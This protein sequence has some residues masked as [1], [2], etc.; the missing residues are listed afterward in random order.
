MLTFRQKI[1]HKNVMVVG[2]I[3]LDSFVQGVVERISPE[4]P[5][6]VLS[7]TSETRMLGGA[8]NALRNL[9][10]LGAKSSIISLTGNDAAR[11]TL[12]RHV[13][14]TGVSSSSL[15]ADPSRPTTQKTRFVSGQHQLLRA[16]L[17]KTHNP[18]ED[19]E[20]ALIDAIEAAM[21]DADALVLSDYGKGVLSERVI[22]ASIEAARAKGAPVLVDPKGANF[23][24]Y[25]GAGVITPNRKELSAALGGMPAHTDEEIEIAA[26]RLIEKTGIDTVIVTRSEDGLS[27]IKKETAPVHIRGA[28]LEVFDVSGAGD[29][30]IATLAAGLACGLDIETAARLANEAGGIVVGK[31][32]TAQITIDDLISAIMPETA[33]KHMAS[34][35]QARERIER[36]RAQ[37]LKIGFT[38][39]CF[40]ILHA[41]HARYLNTARKKC[42]R[43][44]LGLNADSSVRRLKGETRPVNNENDR[45]EVLAA[46]GCVDMVVVFGD[47]PGEQDMPCELIAF[48]KPDIH[49]KGGD[50]KPKD[51]PEAKIVWAYGGEVE[52]L[53]LVAGLS[54]TNTLKKMAS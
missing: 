8:G 42:D 45:A 20:R 2:D 41:G 3:M 6:P 17:E 52:V 21:S 53:D 33:S 25:A 24:K 12:K 32:G 31:S 22:S 48:L 54:T 23:T 18:G 35:E 11:E 4:S 36:W 27:V 39:G 7:V 29:T 30:V 43:L 40:D 50:Y 37:G 9:A 51:L 1:I 16:D 15:I 13:E 28:A 19:I 47:D 38:N 49:F 5:V 34:R 14:S 44:I 46:L 26:N 10:G